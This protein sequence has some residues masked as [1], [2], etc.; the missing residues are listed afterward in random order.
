MSKGLRGLESAFRRFRVRTTPG[1][2]V[3]TS[4]K[5]PERGSASFCRETG[6]RAGGTI[7]HYLLTSAQ[8]C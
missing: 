5:M 6:D 4:L 3:L 1:R 2:G 7:N 8:T